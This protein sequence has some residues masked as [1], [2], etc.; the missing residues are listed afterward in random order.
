M[1]GTPQLRGPLYYTYNYMLMTLNAFLSQ[2]KSSYIVPQIYLLTSISFDR[3]SP[4]MQIAS[5]RSRY[6]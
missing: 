5:I 1:Y 4:G 6:P 3:P 2:G